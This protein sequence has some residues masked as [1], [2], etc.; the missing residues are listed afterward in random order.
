MEQVSVSSFKATCLDWIR[1]V[2]ESGQPVVIT[3]RGQVV[4]QLVPPPP[5]P[6]G[7]HWLGAESGTG[8]IVGDILSP[9]GSEAWEVLEEA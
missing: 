1:R 5:T 6:A 7:P 2:E 4:A 3:R 8:R 9:V